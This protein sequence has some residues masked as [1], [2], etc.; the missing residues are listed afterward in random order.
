MKIF[1]WVTLSQGA[2][3]EAEINR[4][5]RLIDRSIGVNNKPQ[6]YI[7]QK[8]ID[9]IKLNLKKGSKV[10]L[11]FDVEA[12]F[13]SSQILYEDNNLVA[14]FKPAGV[15][16]Q[17][18]RRVIEDNIYFQ[19]KSYYLEISKNKSF[20]PYVGLH[21]RL[22]RQTSGIMIFTKKRSANKHVSDLFKNQKIKKEYLAI[23]HST[24]KIKF[25]QE[26]SQN[27][28]LQRDNS[29]SEIKFKVSD[30]GDLAISDFKI[31]TDLGQ[32][33]YLILCLP[34]TGRTHQ[35]RIQLA[36]KGLPIWG[37][38]VYGNGKKTDNLFLHA[39]QIHFKNLND[40]MIS[41]KAPVPDYWNGYLKNL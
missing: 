33:K 36:H 27:N 25:P 34:K 35:L 7:D 3:V 24:E 29:S 13:T 9:S 40:K 23:V 6:V 21:H 19:L 14:V 38:S 1:E 8:K 31:L 2:N 11:V 20:I 18:T 12:N 28:F 16:S 17:P 37:D 26:W 41:V 15:P 5:K 4:F 22:D 39:S 30:K 32:Q 10:S